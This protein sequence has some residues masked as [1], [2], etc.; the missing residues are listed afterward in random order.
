MIEV[1]T[2]DEKDTVSPP[3]VIMSGKKAENLGE[4]SKKLQPAKKKF[5]IGKFHDRIDEISASDSPKITNSKSIEAFQKFS[6]QNVQFLTNLTTVEEREP[7][8][9]TNQ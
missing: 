8:R 5:S 4:S 3:Q 1:V 9:G 7:S 2:G 6:Q